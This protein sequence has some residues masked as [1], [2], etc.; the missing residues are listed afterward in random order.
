MV[1][2]YAVNLGTNPPDRA[3]IFQGE[4]RL[5][6][7]ELEKRIHPGKMQ[8]ALQPQWRYPS[9]VV[10]VNVPWQLDEG[11]HVPP[12]SDGFDLDVVS[13]HYLQPSAEGYR[14]LFVRR[15]AVQ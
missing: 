9:P 11:L 4:P 7:P 2:I 12:G 13:L 3:G 6:G 15:R 1:L 10:T 8:P 5:P 14:G